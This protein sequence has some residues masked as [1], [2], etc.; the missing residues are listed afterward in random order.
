MHDR[1]RAGSPVA[2]RSAHSVP[3]PQGATLTIRPPTTAPAPA[4][5]SSPSTSVASTPVSVPGGVVAVGDSIMIDAQRPLE[6]DVPGI[7]VDAAISRQWAQGEQLLTQLK[8]A[9]HLPA[10]VVV[11][12]GTNGPIASSDFAAMMAILSGVT[13]A[14]FVTVHVDRPWQNEVNEVLSA[15]V[16][17][18]PNAVLAD[19]QGLASQHPEWFYGDGTHLPPGGAGAQALAGVIASHV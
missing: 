14:V 3:A 8:Q 11:D 12:L 5:A 16:T 13:R 7:T 9:G 4:V 18:Y 10:V 19:W 2:L 17:K 6:A 1:D 15:G